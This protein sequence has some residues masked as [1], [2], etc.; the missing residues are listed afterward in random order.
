VT[1][2]GRCGQPTGAGPH[3]DCDRLL[4]LEPPRY[5]DTCARRMKVQV[6]PMGWAATCVQHGQI[7]SPAQGTGQGSTTT[8]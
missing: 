4:V 8:P 6:S 1:Y 5:C 2:C 3:P 7:A